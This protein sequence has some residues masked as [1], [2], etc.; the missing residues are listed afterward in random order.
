MKYRIDICDDWSSTAGL[1]KRE[2][3]WFPTDKDAEEYAE[4]Q[5]EDTGYTYFVNRV[6]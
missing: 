3:L 2:I 1:V 5:V 4:A 6:R